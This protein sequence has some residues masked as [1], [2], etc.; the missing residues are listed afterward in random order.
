[1]AVI[2]ATNDLKEQIPINYLSLCFYEEI[3]LILT[4]KQPYCL[5]T[6]NLINAKSIRTFKWT[7][8]SKKEDFY[9]FRVLRIFAVLYFRQMW[10]L[11]QLKNENDKPLCMKEIKY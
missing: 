6:Q 2:N 3:L 8:F 9:S 10:V 11:S 1:M 7:I 5:S 4:H